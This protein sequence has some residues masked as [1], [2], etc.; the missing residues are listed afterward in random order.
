M[1]PRHGPSSGK[2]KQTHI[3]NVSNNYDP[4]C[5]EV[6]DNTTAINIDTLT[7]ALATVTMP[8]EIGPNQCGSL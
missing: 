3:V 4:Q 7:E 5:D 2:Q 8:A 6:C 1:S